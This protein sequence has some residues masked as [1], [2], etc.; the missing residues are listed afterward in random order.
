MRALFGLVSLL[1]VV[2]IVMYLFAQHTSQV[3]NV[4]KNVR[5]QVEQLA[6]VDENGARVTESYTLDPETDNGKL[7]GM[8]VTKLAPDSA[9][10]KFYG[11]QEGD[12]ITE[13]SPQGSVM[14]S[15]H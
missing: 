14:M 11:L 9:M 2:A 1:V 7:K 13:A 8:K 4:N 6:G 12:L 3:S 15:V 10:R 5:P